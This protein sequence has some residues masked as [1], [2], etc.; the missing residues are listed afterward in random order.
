[1][2]KRSRR[3]LAC[4]TKLKACETRAAERSMVPRAGIEPATYGL[5]N[6]RSVQL[7]YRGVFLSKLAATILHDKPIVTRAPCCG[8]DLM[9]LNRVSA[10]TVQQDC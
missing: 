3:K 7:S 9:F 5:G 1:M 8:I 4:H 10:E 6:R 2:S